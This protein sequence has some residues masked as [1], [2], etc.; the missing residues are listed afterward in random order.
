MPNCFSYD[1]QKRLF[2]VVASGLALIILSPLLLAIAVLVLTFG[3]RPVFFIQV[4]AGKKGAPF[5]LI[6]FRTMKRSVAGLSLEEKDRIS[7][8]GAFLRASSLDEL[9]SLVNVIRGEMSLVGPRPLLMEYLKYYSIHHSQRH[10][11]RPG[12][13]GLAQVKGR[14]LLTWE[15]RLD[16]DVE[17]IHNMSFRVDILIL[18]RTSLMVLRAKGVNQPNGG[19]MSPLEDG[20]E[21]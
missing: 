16:F 2:D 19:L 10:A 18:L 15:E 8:L 17:Y 4:R 7:R 14:N 21:T 1:T 11:T 12:L 5:R 6:K 20:Y 13:T 3:G 9:P